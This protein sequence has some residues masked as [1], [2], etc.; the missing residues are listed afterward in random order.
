MKLGPQQNRQHFLDIKH[1][2]IIAKTNKHKG[3]LHAN[4]GLFPVF[5]N[6]H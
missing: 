6:H 5:R 4:N 1:K 2:Q 3:T